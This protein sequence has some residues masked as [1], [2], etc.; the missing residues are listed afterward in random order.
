MVKRRVKDGRTLAQL[1][2]VGRATLKDL[3]LLGVRTVAQ[4]ARRS[5]GR[6]YERLCGLTGCR[7]DP[8]VLDVFAAAVAQAR[9][10]GLPAA[11]RDWWW[12]SRK[13]KAAGKRAR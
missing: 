3:E 13:R 12:W 10:P 9:D 4:L 6:M 2:G 8:C 5:P 7:Q 1:A 11:Q